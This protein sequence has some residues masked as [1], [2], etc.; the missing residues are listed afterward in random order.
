MSLIDSILLTVL[1]TVVCLVLPKLLSIILP[2]QKTQINQ[3][4][5]EINIPP[6]ATSETSAEIPPYKT[7]SN[8]V[9]YSYI[10]IGRF[11]I[12]LSNQ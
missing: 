4:K 2:T 3:E 5:K 1:N 6:S 12:F 8:I 10:L 11:M 9:I 7:Y